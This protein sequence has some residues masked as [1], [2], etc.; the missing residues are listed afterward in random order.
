MRGIAYNRD[1]SSRKA[2][3]K[4]KLSDSWLVG[5]SPWYNNLH[6]Y[7]KNKIHCS[8]FLSYYIVGIV[9]PSIM[10]SVP[11]RYPALGETRKPTS[12]AISSG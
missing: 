3:H 6:Q 11:V 1:I 4:K 5:C 8:C 2:F 10:Y 7:S 9:P 12:S